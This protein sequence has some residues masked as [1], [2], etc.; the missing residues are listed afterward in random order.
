MPGYS[1]RNGLTLPERGRLFTF[2]KSHNKSYDR[3]KHNYK[4]DQILICNH[5]HQLLLHSVRQL[6]YHGDKRFVH[7]AM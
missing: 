2:Y 4:L 1:K 7:I 6:T 3:A 5:W